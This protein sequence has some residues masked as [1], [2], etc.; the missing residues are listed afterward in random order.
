VHV[1][2]GY[3]FSGRIG[4]IGFDVLR[5][6]PKYAFLVENNRQLLPQLVGGYWS[7]D[8][9][10]AFLVENNRQLLPQL[11]GGYWPAQLRQR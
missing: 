11:V 3:T 6:D 1:S 8:P 4:C 10:Y 9:K 2:I 5:A 7:A